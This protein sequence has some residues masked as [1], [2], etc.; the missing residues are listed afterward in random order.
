MS[1]YTKSQNAISVRGCALL[2]KP[3]GQAAVF[4]EGNRW[5]SKQTSY[6]GNKYIYIPALNIIL[7]MTV[8]GDTVS[9]PEF[10]NDLT[11]NHSLRNTIISD[12]VCVYDMP[13]YAVTLWKYLVGGVSL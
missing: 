3:A 1:L 6:F 8:L 10:V 13:C 4:L 11:S 5:I 2:M 9:F 7:H 12:Q